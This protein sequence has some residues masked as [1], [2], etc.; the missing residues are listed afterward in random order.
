[1]KH[2]NT[3]T[4]I[5]ALLKSTFEQ[6]YLF[7]RSF[8][9]SY[10]SFRNRYEQNTHIAPINIHTNMSLYMYPHSYTY[11]VMHTHTNT[12]TQTHA[13]THTHTHINTNIFP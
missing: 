2:T 12:H 9:H 5:Q 1:M 7:D 8:K 11:R 13:H 4:H 3:H 10:K 6:L